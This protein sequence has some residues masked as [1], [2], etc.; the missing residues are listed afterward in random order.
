ME[1]IEE[2]KTSPHST[3]SCRWRPPSSIELILKRPDPL[4]GR[5]RTRDRPLAVDDEER[6]ARD[7]HLGGLPLDG[8]DELFSA[9]RCRAHRRRRLDRAPT[10]RRSHAGRLGRR[11][12]GPPRNRRGTGRPRP[13]R[14]VHAARR[15]QSACGRAACSACA[16]SCRRRSRCPPGARARPSAHRAGRC[17]PPRTCGRGRAR[18][19]CPRPAWWDSARTAA[20]RS[21]WSRA[22]RADRGRVR[23]GACRRSTTGRS[24]RRTRR[25]SATWRTP[26]RPRHRRSRPR[27]PALLGSRSGACSACARSAAERFLGIGCYTPSCHERPRR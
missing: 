18:A 22:A 6:H 17:A 19:P 24:R 10:R 7:L 26:H 8:L 4:L 13:G 2:V 12:P 5:L 1:G 11:R 20:T 27:A 14:P 3:S 16:S 25:W 15:P 21:R 9:A 23:A